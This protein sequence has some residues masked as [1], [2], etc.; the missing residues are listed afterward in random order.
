MGSLRR[1]WHPLFFFFRPCVL[2][3]LIRI[4]KLAWRWGGGGGKGIYRGS[5]DK[6]AGGGGRQLGGVEWEKEG[7]RV[8]LKNY[9]NYENTTCELYHVLFPHS[10]T[11]RG[12]LVMTFMRWISVNGR[13]S[14]RF[15]VG[16]S[17]RPF[18]AAVGYPDC[19]PI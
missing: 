9:L 3:S 8:N 13:G 1:F 10:T 17:T 2:A 18:H 12:L 19:L 11:R 14:V 16:S 4:R 5:D 15:W 7:G 6:G